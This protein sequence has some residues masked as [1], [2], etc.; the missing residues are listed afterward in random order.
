MA[1]RLP[2]LFIPHGGGPCFFMEPAWG[3]PKDA[4]DGMAA[5][6][7]DL[8]A[9]L[10]VKPKALL[11]VSGHWE[12]ER[13]TVNTAAAPALLYDYYGF[14]EHTY[15]LAWPAPGAPE[16][17]AQV[18]ALLAGAGLES[19][20]DDRRGLD[21]GVFVPLKVAFP[22]ADIPVVQLSL[23]Q[24]LDPATHLAIGRALAP[25][26]EQGVLIVGSGMSYHNLR[27]FFTSRG[28]EAA[29]AFDAWLTDAVTADPAEREQ[30]LTQWADAPGARQ[31]HPEP[32]HLLPLMVAAGAAG[33]DAGARTYADHVAGKALSGFQ[34]G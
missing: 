15:R 7:R 22:E 5:Y 10:G 17:A 11:V 4:W 25:L 33:A 18:R 24:G 23:Q 1:D 31:S 14:P 6:R 13:P 34:F 30:R 26:R 9:A 20:A 12:A 27:E 19:D 21:H 28:G 2:T 3:L 29:E 8:P 32:E 16:L